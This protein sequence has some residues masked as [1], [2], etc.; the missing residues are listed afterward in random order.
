MDEPR[1]VFDQ[2]ESQAGGRLREF[3]VLKFR[4][5]LGYSPNL[6]SPNTFN[7]KV[8]HKMLFDRR[9]ILTTFAD[10]LAVRTYVEQRLAGQEHLPMIYRVFAQA[11]DLYGFTFPSRFVLKSNHGSGWNY[12]HSGGSFNRVRLV[13]RSRRWLQT[14]YGQNM[15]EWCYNGI[16]PKVFCEEYL[17]SDNRVPVDFRFYCFSGTVRFITVVFDRFV[18]PKRNTYDRDWNRLDVD[19]LFPPKFLDPPGPPESLV[20]MTAIAEQLSDGIDF[21]R[22]DLYDLGN[23]VVFGE[24]TNYP[25]AGRARFCPQK[26]DATFGSYWHV[27]DF[28]ECPL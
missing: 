3:L 8:L 18:A 28:S 11:D 22:V 7:E 25:D 13:Q 21:V 14:N 23:R 26:W 27:A 16:Q 12:V 15:G 5:E 9:P 1:F 24:L 19:W 20:R 4:T 2:T 10:K 17:G 6:S